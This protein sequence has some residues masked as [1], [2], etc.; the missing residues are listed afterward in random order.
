MQDGPPASFE[1]AGFSRII[2]YH[3]EGRDLAPKAEHVYSLGPF[4]REPNFAEQEVSG[5]LVDL[6][7][8]SSTRLLALERVFIRELSGEKRDVTRARI[9]D[10]DL[11][12]A[13][14]VSNIASLTSDS[15]ESDWR[16]VRKE[17]FLDLDDVVPRLSE[18]YRK[19]DN[20]EAMGLGPELPG[21]GRALLL[22]S[23]DNFRETQRT[24]FLLFRLT[25]SE[26][27]EPS[28]EVR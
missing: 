20:L 25:S 8:L 24:Q 18:T 12:T 17:L 26:L 15:P 19:L 11:E 6:V 14:D 28:R 7:A 10:V 3:V 16:P 1:N 23:D 5:G 9:Y 22:A 2:T 27:D 4:A 21:G 13:S